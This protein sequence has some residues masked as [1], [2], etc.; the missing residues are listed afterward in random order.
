MQLYSRGGGVG[1]KTPSGSGGGGGGGLL[2]QMNQWS[3]AAAGA[4]RT[5]LDSGRTGRPGH[6]AAPAAATAAAATAASRGR[7]PSKF[8]LSHNPAALVLGGAR[9]P[10]STA[11]LASDAPPSRPEGS[12]T[13][14]P[15]ADS[16]GIPPPAKDEQE[17]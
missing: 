6:H 17:R 9:V 16:A 2:D 7:Q 5:E 8:K 13:A 10:D 1:D 11:V 15:T 4:A 12:G 14:T 3:G